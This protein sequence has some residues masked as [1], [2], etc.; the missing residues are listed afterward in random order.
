MKSFNH[1]LEARAK[2]ALVSLALMAAAVFV[3]RLT[4]EQLYNWIAGGGSNMP[5]YKN[6]LDEEQM[7]ALV[8]H[9]RELQK[10]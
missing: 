2:A 3:V 9:V 10:H 1:L 7:R 4:D 6:T 5:S 8:K